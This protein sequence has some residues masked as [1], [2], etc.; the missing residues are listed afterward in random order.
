MIETKGCFWD[1]FKNVKRGV[2]WFLCA[3]PALALVIFVVLWILAGSVASPDRRPLQDYHQ[4]YFER[5]EEDGLVVARVDLLE[6]H[7][8]GL[9]VKADAGSGPAKRGKLLR[10]QLVADGVTLPAYGEIK[11][12]LV[13]LHGRNGRKEDLLPVAERFC[14][15]G[16][17]CVIPDLPAHGDSPTETVGFGTR[18]FEVQLP[19]DVADEVKALLGMPDLPEYLWGMSMGGSFAVHAAAFQKDRWKRITIVA[20]FDRL[21]GVFEDSLGMFSEPFQSLAESMI[22]LRGGVKVKLVNP[23]DLAGKIDSPVLV[24]HG[25]KDHLIPHS[26]GEALYRAFAGEKKFITIPGGNH[27][28]VLVTEAPVYAEMAKWYL[29]SL[30]QGS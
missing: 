9:L 29:K 11:A 10:D 19:G 12:L 21:S 24:V 22:E 15:V 30:R 1:G 14:A 4:S 25:D 5:P 28:N 27:D 20:S 2:K 18:K 16:F 8:P 17:A 26:R 13:L 3:L 7:V 6:G 23:V